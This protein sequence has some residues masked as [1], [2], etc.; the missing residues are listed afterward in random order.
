MHFNAPGDFEV[1][2][3][4]SA[5]FRTEEYELFRTPRIHEWVEEFGLELIG[6]RGLRDELRAR[7]A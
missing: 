2:N 5:P 1:V 4:W 6:M 7:T 3:A